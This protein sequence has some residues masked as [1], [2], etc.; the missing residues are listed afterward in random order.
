MNSFF[1]GQRRPTLTE[2]IRQS[3]EYSEV[4][5]AFKRV[6]QLKSGLV[7]NKKPNTYKLSKKLNE[8]RR[9]N[10]HDF[11]EH[12]K[13]LASLQRRLTSLGSVSYSVY[14]TFN[15]PKT[16]KRIPGTRLLTPA[17]SLGER[18]SSMK[19]LHLETLLQ[20]FNK[21]SRRLCVMPRSFIRS[22]SRRPEGT[23]SK[24]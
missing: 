20:K 15:R 24:L 12:I 11:E 19:T 14:F 1:G 18:T 8:N 10:M 23:Q 3:P 5:E 16:G 17:Y 7:D 6:K 4:R 9:R 21:T 2:K 13:N 22:S